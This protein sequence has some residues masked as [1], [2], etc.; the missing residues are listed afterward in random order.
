M[1]EMN[2]SNA[3]NWNYSSTLDIFIPEN[4][5]NLGF[6]VFGGVLKGH[7]RTKYNVHVLSGSLDDV[8]TV[9]LDFGYNVTV[10]NTINDKI[11]I[12]TNN[13]IGL[14]NKN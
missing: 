8:N 12:T 3:Y 14:F 11:L 4:A 1:R 5:N 9:S 10:I 6:D 2:F 13:N 7:Q